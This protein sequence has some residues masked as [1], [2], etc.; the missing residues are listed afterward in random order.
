VERVRSRGQ[1]HRL[2]A[3]VRIKGR[4]TVAPGTKFTADGANAAE[5]T[6]AVY[7]PALDEVVGFA[8]VRTEALHNR[9]PL[10]VA[11]SE[12]PIEA[13]LP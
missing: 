5:V 7:S 3:P 9:P 6:S 12:P 10:V 4:S 1:V 13:Y 11:G 8:Y 2:L